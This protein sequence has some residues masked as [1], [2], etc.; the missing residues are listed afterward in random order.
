[1]TIVADPPRA[2]D[3]LEVT[4]GVDTHADFHVAAVI[5]V[6]GRQLDDASFPTTHPAAGAQRVGRDPRD[7][8]RGRCRCGPAPRA[9]GTRAL[10]QAG[11]VVVEVYRPDRSARRDQGKSDPLDAHAA[12]RGL[13]PRSLATTSPH[14]YIDAPPEPRHPAARNELAGAR[15]AR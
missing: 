7:R 9:P 14:S 12:A 13:I 2:V 8:H 1:M 5:D 3:V 6:L 4:A 10:H 11:V 15:P